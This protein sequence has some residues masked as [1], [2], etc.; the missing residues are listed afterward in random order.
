MLSPLLWCAAVAAVAAGL[1]SQQRA[2]EEVF[3]DA[4]VK[5]LC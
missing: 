1:E 3:F 4:C 5:C 2:A